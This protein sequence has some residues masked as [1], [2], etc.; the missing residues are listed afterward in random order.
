MEINLLDNLSD[1]SNLNLNNEYKY[2]LFNQDSNKRKIYIYKFL[3]IKLT[4]DSLFYPNILLYSN[5]SKN[6]Y[7]PINEKTM[8]LKLV[9]DNNT[10][11]YIE[12]NIKS[13]FNDPLFF[14]IYNFDNYYHFLY[15]TLPYL[16]TYKY[17]KT[18]IKNIKLLVNYPNKHKQS[19]Y[20]FNIEFFELLDI[21][22]DDFIIVDNSVQYTNIYV[23]SSY[24]H[25]NLSNIEPRNEIYEL[26]HHIRT[27]ALEKDIR[28]ELPKNIYISRRTYIHNKL[29]NIGTN[30]TQRRKMINEDILV[31]I[32]EKSNYKE[33]F[34]ENLTTIEKIHLFYN[35]KNII[36]SIGGGIA[37]VVFSKPET[38]LYAIISPGFMNINFRFKFCL[39]KVNCRY[40]YDTY[41]SELTKFKKYMRIKDIESNTIGEIDEVNEDSVII[42]YLDETLAGWN[43]S[44]QYKSKTVLN[45]NVLKLDEGLNSSYNLDIN[46]LISYLNIELDNN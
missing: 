11:N 9:K 3:N 4:G 14:F 42:N 27:K 28:L 39:N 6:L 23:S 10:Y 45:K 41:H 46:K 16:I 32:L 36:G 12:S 29:D 34:T 43:N 40:I 31:K 8:S 38:N 20:D 18:I 37:N 5:Y 33:I 26:Y 24:T 21:S 44:I 25:D 30:Y 2:L 1:S 19:F 22:Y 15:D 35:C 13:K 7:N 17:L